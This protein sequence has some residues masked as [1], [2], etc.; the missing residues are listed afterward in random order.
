RPLRMTARLNC[1]SSTMMML[2][3]WLMFPLQ[4]AAYPGMPSLLRELP[5]SVCVSPQPSCDW[6]LPQNAV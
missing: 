3:A 1:M 2:R 5:V 4:T 6:N